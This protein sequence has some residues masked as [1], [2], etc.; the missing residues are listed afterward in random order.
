MSYYGSD[1]SIHKQSD[2]IDIKIDSMV[3]AIE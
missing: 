3:Q 1:R 2:N